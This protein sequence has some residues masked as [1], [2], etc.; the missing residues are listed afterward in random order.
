MSQ[1]RKQNV[2]VS[3]NTQTIQKAKILAA[4]RS[5]SISALLAQQIEGLVEADEKYQA[6]CASALALMDRGFHLGGAGIGSRDD[7]HER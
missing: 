4:Q 5:T 7:L 3:L 2:T 1:I 6:A